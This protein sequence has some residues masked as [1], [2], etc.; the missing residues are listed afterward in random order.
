MSWHDSDR[1]DNTIYKVVVNHEEQYSI[2]PA[3]RENAL[4]WRDAGKSGPKT[5]CLEYIKEVWTDMRPLSLRRRM[6]ELAKNPPPPPPPPSKEPRPPGDDLVNR[7]SQGQHLLEASLR[8]KRTAQA[9]KDRIDMGYVH[10]KF[11]E[12]RG[13]TELGVQLDP[14]AI[15]LSNADF[16]EC[17]G[18]VHLEGTLTL[19]YIPVRCVADI[20]LESLGGQGHLVQIQQGELLSRSSSRSAGASRI[21]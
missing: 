17:K 12:T 21:N 18:S 10:I 15:N 2:W 16:D 1:V 13:G 9:L 3:D 5:E 7:L 8:P 11:T 6:E 20:D 14:D 19:N 4:G